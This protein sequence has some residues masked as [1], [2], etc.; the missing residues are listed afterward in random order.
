M[1]VSH[2]RGGTP[3]SALTSLCDSKQSRMKEL[4]KL[5]PVRKL[6]I[7]KDLFFEHL[8]SAYWQRTCGRNCVLSEP[9]ITILD[10]KALTLKLF[11]KSSRLALVFFSVITVLAYLTSLC[12]QLQHN[13]VP[14]G[15]E[16][17]SFWS[18]IGSD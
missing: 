17:S 2:S 12:L 9:V 8:G 7:E 6:R 14:F 16:S 11:K 10:E 4:W 3:C 18:N 13:R 1:S 15:S 5:S